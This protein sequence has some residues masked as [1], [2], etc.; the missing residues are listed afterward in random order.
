MGAG[1][2]GL[3]PG[4][5]RRVDR[6][7]RGRTGWRGGE[8]EL[9][10]PAGGDG[11]SRRAGRELGRGAEALPQGD[12]ELLAGPVP[13]LRWVRLAADGQRP[14]TALRAHRYHER[15]SSGRKVASPGLVVR[16]SVRLPSALAPRVRGEVQGD[17]L[18]PSDLD[19]WANCVPV[20][21]GDRRCGAGPAVPP[22]PGGLPTRAGGCPYQENFATLV[23]FSLPPCARVPDWGGWGSFRHCGFRFA[24][25]GATRPFIYS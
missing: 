11:T 16:G 12:A 9:S 24:N 17:D 1:R 2:G 5:P 18:V 14:G 15:R 13:L 20:W 25:E 22:R 7:E 6:G 10:W 8:G 19:A 4:V 3:R 23:F 21:S